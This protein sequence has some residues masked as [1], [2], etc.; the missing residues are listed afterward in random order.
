MFHGPGLWL[1]QPCIAVNMN[2]SWGRYAPLFVSERL[3]ELYDI[4]EARGTS[5]VEL[6]KIR[7]RNVPGVLHF[8][9]LLFDGQ[10]P[11]VAPGISFENVLRR[12]KHLTEFRDRMPELLKAY[13]KARVS[14]KISATLPDG[15]MLAKK[16]GLA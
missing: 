4:M 6:D 13:D 11:H 8:L 14:G 9:R 1:G 16:Y 3:P 7:E 12:F 2:V 5:S 10:V 15:G